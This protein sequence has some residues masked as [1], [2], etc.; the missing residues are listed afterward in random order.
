[1]QIHGKFGT[2]MEAQ[3]TVS[4]IHM[5]T[6]F[7]KHDAEPGVGDVD[8]VI[9]KQPYYF[10]TVM[11]AVNTTSNLLRGR[12][13]DV[14]N[15]DVHNHIIRN[16]VR[17]VRSSTIEGIR[18]AYLDHAS[19]IMTHSQRNEDRDL[20]AY[21]IHL[22]AKVPFEEQIANILNSI[23]KENENSLPYKISLMFAFM[24]FTPSTGRVGYW[25]ANSHLSHDSRANDRDLLQQRDNIWNISNEADMQMC[26]SDVQNND[27][28]TLMRNQLDDSNS[29]ILRC[30]NVRIQIFPTADNGVG[31]GED[32]DDDDH[33]H[34]MPPTNG[35]DDNDDNDEDHDGSFEINDD[36]ADENSRDVAAEGE[37]I[38]ETEDQRSK[39]VIKGFL[40]KKSQEGYYLWSIKQMRNNHHST[41]DSK[42]FFHCLAVRELL[43]ENNYTT[44]YFFRIKRDDEIRLKSKQL[45]EKYA[46][47][48]NLTAVDK[49][50]F[51]G[52]HFSIIPQLEHLYG[53]R[54]NIYTI[55][56]IYNPE[57]KVST[58][59]F[60]T[61]AMSKTRFV[62]NTKKRMDLI[63]YDNH[64][65]LILDKDAI[66]NDRFMCF[67][68]GHQFSRLQSLQ[69]HT[70]ESCELIKPKEQYASGAVMTAKLLLEQI[71][72]Q[73][74]VPD[75]ILRPLVYS[76]E[77]HEEGML[78]RNEND[79]YF[80]NK[81]A[82]FD[83]ESKLSATTIKEIRDGRLNYVKETYGDEE[84]IN[85]YL[86]AEE[87]EHEAIEAYINNEEVYDDEG[88]L[89]TG[90]EFKEKYGD[91]DYVLE[92]V[93]VSYLIAYN[94]GSSSTEEY[95]F[96]EPLSYSDRCTIEG[97]QVAITRSNANP[98]ELISSFYGD[99]KD[100]CKAYRSENLQY[101]ENLLDYLKEWFDERNLVLNIDAAVGGENDDTTFNDDL[102]L[103]NE[104]QN[105]H[106]NGIE[107]AYPKDNP[108]NI[109][110]GAVTLTIDDL[111]HDGKT[112]M[113]SLSQEIKL[114]QD[115][116][117]F[118]EMLVV[119]GY[120][121]GKY[122]IPLI[123]P[124]LFHEI[125]VA[126]AH[127]T[128]K[129][130][131]HM[132][133]KGSSYIGIQLTNMTSP[134]CFGF[135]L[136]DMREFTGPGGNLRTFMC[137]F[138]DD[139]NITTDQEQTEEDRILKGNFFFPYEWLTSYEKLEETTD[140][141]PKEA[142]FSKLK[143]ENVLDEGLNA[144]IRKN[145]LFHLKKEKVLQ[146][147]G[148][149]LSGEEY[150]DLIKRV[151]QR[152]EWKN[153]LDYLL[154]YNEMNVRPFLRSISVYLKALFQHKVNP[155]FSCYSLPGVAKKFYQVICLQVPYTIL[156]MRKYL[157][158]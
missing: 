86:V 85:D 119:V 156:I 4:A 110:D 44:T 141:P 113:K 17:S 143:D 151:W 122:D 74:D 47:T 128:D 40:S 101:Y 155:L 102:E 107:I 27:F 146:R 108:S 94:F 100:V 23:Y 145:N 73:F 123:K 98:K 114:M 144:Y 1:M 124:Y 138:A 58:I 31:C 115:F 75:E 77:Q 7:M 48:F 50:L 67:K 120:D 88:N 80:T 83:F 76:N 129:Q 157:S 153:M 127:P 118:L 99:L 28:F 61:A 158:Y 70:R 13:V 68:C 81:F 103:I 53:C 89:I 116:K 117:R 82:T 16:S 35:N 18:K 69:R 150:Y 49:T 37:G 21:N 8:K 149:P 60:D 56:S 29:V 54:I 2:S 154:F 71:K 84:T 104:N 79:D 135:V 91:E 133:K 148:R 33:H 96:V 92:N 12:G 72:N 45:F 125:F 78:R 10:D 90:R 20:L 55:E 93:P 147:E 130:H 66:L 30:T 136:K 126:D 152:K 64:Y 65:Y 59:H 134:G 63:F 32:D 57:L 6:N 112:M 121:S 109:T 41:K 22:M 137:A 95:E 62:Y 9:S 11:R 132:I 140:F 142:F 51:N 34:F 42:C 19:E 139:S 87:M 36:D 14:D 3:P 52:V 105:E 38:E 5:F 97:D 26:I 46:K 43:Y 39:R 131:F 106:H 24:L 25:H 15:P 111:G